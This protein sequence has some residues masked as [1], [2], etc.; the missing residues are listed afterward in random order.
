MNKM[1]QNREADIVYKYKDRNIF[2]LI[3][4]QTKIDYS[5]PYRIL[6]YE[7]AIMRSAVEIKKL[8]T[9]EYKLPL[10]VPIVLYTGKQKWNSK[11]YIEES[12]EKLYDVKIK[13]GNY[14]LVDIN[15]Y[16]KEELLKSKTITAKIMLLEKS[17]STE[18]TI[19]ML[20]EVIPNIKEEY[21]EL[22]KRVIS[23]LLEEKIGKEKAEEL[24]NKINGGEEEM[25]AL[26][27]MVRNENQM[28]INIGKEE[29]RKN[30]EKKCR[31]IV[32]NLLK[33]K[34]PISQISEVTKLTE[35]EIEKL[36][37]Q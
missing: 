29:E 5:M 34:M 8:K 18:E 15:D 16:T 32:K 12:Q 22:L 14:N 4:H 10:V 7:M 28:Y 11:Q 23:M 25:L 37:Q 35:E 1:F 36:K 3:E 13:V 9:K 2:F 30:S 21:K 27:D 20:E 17:K 33:L 6:E 31:E 26:L 19:K 24:I